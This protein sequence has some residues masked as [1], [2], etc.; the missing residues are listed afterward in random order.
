MNGIFSAEKRLR[1]LFAAAVFLPVPRPFPQPRSVSGKCAALNSKDARY[2]LSP[3]GYRRR[4]VLPGM[5]QTK[6]TPIRFDEAISSE[7]A[8]FC[9]HSA[10]LYAQIVGESLAV[11]G[12]CQRYC[13]RSAGP[14]MPD[15]QEVFPGCAS[16]SHFDLLSQE[17]VLLRRE[18]PSSFFIRFHHSLVC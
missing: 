5:P 10:P 16:G 18:H 2:P 15:R 9:R 14:P 4:P 8:D 12:G 7:F 1:Q 17:Q 3:G 11:I 6:M 13:C